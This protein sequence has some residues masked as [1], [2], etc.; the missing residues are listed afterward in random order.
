MS[1]NTTQLPGIG[2]KYEIDTEA[3]DR[4][5]IVTT[6]TGRQQLYLLPQKCAEPLSIELTPAES[7]RIGSIL[8]GAF[9]LPDDE[10]V[11][12]AFSTLHDLRITIRKYRP[13]E[14]MIGRSLKDLEV[15][16]KT[17]AS[18][19]AVSREGQNIIN[20]PA[21]LVFER[22]DLVIAFGEHDHLAAFEEQM[23]L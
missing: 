19:L 15:R 9:M 7:L 8:T 13:S 16:K 10:G 18:I 4:V 3:G 22:N 12:I 2:T 5:A 14:M 21:D 11:E 1:Y 20:P 6:Q 23:G 17:G